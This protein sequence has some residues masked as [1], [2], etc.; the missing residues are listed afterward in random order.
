MNFLFML[1]E[2]HCVTINISSQPFQ[3][4]FDPDGGEEV[5]GIDETM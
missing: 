1:M 3:M 2:F 4:F 5:D